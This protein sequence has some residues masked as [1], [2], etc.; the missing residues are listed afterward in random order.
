[1]CSLILRLWVC[2]PMLGR[3]V[4]RSMRSWRLMR[5]KSW[6][7]WTMWRSRRARDFPSSPQNPL[8]PAGTV[9]PPRAPPA[10]EEG[11]ARLKF[12]LLAVRLMAEG[13]WG[14]WVC[15]GRRP[16]GG[17]RAWGMR[18]ARPD[19]PTKLSSRNVRR[20]PVRGLVCRAR[21]MPR[22]SPPGTTVGPCA[23]GRRV[24]RGFRLRRSTT[25]WPLR[26]PPR[27]AG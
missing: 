2:L 17:P 11:A 24:L 6:R 8:P 5:P 4:M 27:P 13:L 1:M 9:K 16:S 19:T 21:T 23:V 3:C 10:Q 20:T 7:V 15:R 18:S 25:R 26:R 12:P 22:N 14:L